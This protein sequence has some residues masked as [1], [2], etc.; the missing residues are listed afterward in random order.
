MYN[1]GGAPKGI[2]VPTGGCS[3]RSSPSCGSFDNP[4]Q[5]FGTNSNTSQD[6]SEVVKSPGGGVVNPAFDIG[7][8]F[9]EASERKLSTTS[10][11]S[12]GEA[13]NA[14]TVPVHKMLNRFKRSKSYSTESPVD[15][16]K[17]SSAKSVETSKFSEFRRLSRVFNRSTSEDGFQSLPPSGVA[18]NAVNY[19][20]DPHSSSSEEHEGRSLPSDIS[21]R[22]RVSSRENLSPSSNSSNGSPDSSS[23]QSSASSSNF[24]LSLET[25]D[26]QLAETHHRKLHTGKNFEVRVDIE[27]NPSS[28]DNL[29][30][31]SHDFIRNEGSS[32]RDSRNSSSSQNSKDETPE[33]PNLDFREVSGSD[34]L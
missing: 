2:S 16:P 25:K 15:G 5:F 6:C 27:F 9:D 26:S 10:F 17:T 33:K 3:L 32:S 4:D 23:S 13:R 28:F 11:G 31:E 24:Y 21:R 18:N 19:V 7:N 22:N 12:L 8:A 34:I 30:S 20:T 14:I 29:Q 1:W